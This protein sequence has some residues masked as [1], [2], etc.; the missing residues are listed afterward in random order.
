MTGRWLFAARVGIGTRRLARQL[1]IW[2]A[3]ADLAGRARAG[4]VL[5]R[6]LGLVAVVWFVGGMLWALGTPPWAVVPIW[7]VWSLGASY[8]AEPAAEHSS[9]PVPAGKGK[10]DAGKLERAI[11]LNALDEITAGKT[12][13]HLWPTL[14]EGL[15]AA[16][17]K[18]FGDLEDK[19][20]RALLAVHQ[21]PVKTV[22]AG[23]IRGRKGVRRADLETLL[24]PTPPPAPAP[25]G[26]REDAADLRKSSSSSQPERGTEGDA[27]TT[28][29]LGDDTLAM[30]GSE[31][32]GR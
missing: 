11:L 6:A 18:Q 26:R 9:A 29:E 23:G 17:P 1:A 24:T 30:L 2:L 31:A 13:A 21:V 16:R 7:L 8:Q 27:C 19:H 20:L 28:Q 15:R 4:T 32:G 3:A 22:T 10:P 12:G 25:S 14:Y 5:S